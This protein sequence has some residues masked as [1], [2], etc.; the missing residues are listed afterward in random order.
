MP[1]APFIVIADDLT[2]AAEIAALGHRHGLAAS[3]VTDGQFPASEADL[4]VFDSDSRLD[5]ER[6]AAEKISRLAQ[7]L[8]PRPHVLLYKKT[9]SVLRG[10][11]RA[12]LEALARGL[13]A[14]KVLLV[15]ANPSLGRTVQSGRY[16]IKG[17]PLHETAFARDPHHPAHSDD[18]KQLLSPD[19]ALPVEAGGP[20]APLPAGGIVVGDATSASDLDAW[21]R[22]AT[23]EVLPA[24]AA[25]FFAALLRQR[26]IVEQKRSTAFVAEEPI[27]V[28]S[29]TT[30][31]AGT[32]LRADADRAGVPIVRMPLDALRDGATATGAVHAWAHAVQDQLAASGR[33]LAV[34]D[35]AVS[36][37]AILARNIRRAFARLVRELVTHRMLRHL[38]VEGGATAAAVVQE[39]GWRELRLVHEWAPGVAALRPAAGGSVAL[40]LKPGS[41][42][43]PPEL[44][45]NLICSSTKS[46][47]A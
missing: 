32:T 3:V 29:G 4:V 35:G 27:L 15:P 16:A 5:G 7:E 23:P 46:L 33:A 45:Q 44:W 1:R 21:A 20:H 13:G 28:V 39:L 25:E 40:T 10:S 19:G 30:S 37:D 43:W 47:P 31:P 38:V 34:F 17:V 22:Q 2:G 14:T 6:A 41:Y 9:D 42:A 36:P 18:V 12:E 26:N 8:A 11:V 24:G